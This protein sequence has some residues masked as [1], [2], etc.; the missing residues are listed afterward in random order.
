[1]KFTVHPLFFIFGLYFAATGKVFSFAAFTLCAL[2]H[3]LGHARA[4]EKCGYKLKRVTLMPYGAVISGDISGIS[5]KDEIKV[6]CAGPFVNLALYIAIIALWWLFPTTYPYTELAATAN[7]ALFLI[8]L[9]PAF[10]LDGGRLLLCTLSLKLKRKTAVLITK[11]T[12]I[13]FSCFLLGLFVYSC[14]TGVNF[15]L[16]FF[17]SFIFA[18]AIHKN[19]NDGY[20]RFY[21]GLSP[22]TVKRPK[23]VKTLAVGTNFTVKKF[24]SLFDGESLYK[25]MI[26]SKTGELLRVYEPH[27]VYGK[28]L[29]LS[30]DSPFFEEHSVHYD[31]H[32]GSYGF[33]YGEGYP[34]IVK[35]YKRKEIEQGNKSENLPKQG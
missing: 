9:I 33:G 19:P 18:G 34:T 35:T 20:V 24:Y 28:L 17:A 26:Y 32:D 29:V 14:F 15:S 16:L 4:A 2:L 11:T 30:L 10:P 27:E 13:I 21:E 8:N 5:Y 31:S 6:V 25:I 1:M 3:E 12:G 7:L 22:L 23:I